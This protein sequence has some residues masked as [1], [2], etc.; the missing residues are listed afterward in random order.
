MDI[1]FIREN[2]ELVDAAAKKK[3]IDF[4]TAKL[5]ELDDKR[6][7][8]LATVEEKRAA[9]NA[10]NIKISSAK[11]PAQRENL[12]KEMKTVKAEL[13]K[14]ETTLKEIIKDWQAEMLRVPNIPDMSVPDGASDAE[15]VELK[16]WGEKPSFNFTAKNHIDLLL[17]H[18]MADFER[19][20]EVSGFRGYF[21]KKD[22]F[23][24][25]F[26]LWQH[27]LDFF[28]KK[29]LDPLL[30]P[31]IVKPFAFLGTGYLPQGA[32]DLYKTQDGDYLSGTAEVP[33]MSYFADS[34]LELASLPKKVLAFSPCYRR[35]AG[36]H[37]KDTKGLMRL[38]E[39]Y[40]FEQVI[41]C[42][43]NHEESVKLHEWITSNAEEFIQSLN[44]PYRVVVNCG[45]DLGLG[46]VKK[47]DIECW[48]PSEN[49]YR[50]THSASYFHDFQ[51]R[52][53]NIKYKDAAGKSQY[54][55]S[56][57]N[58][59]SATP[60][61]LISVVENYQQADGTIRVPE[62]LVKYMGKDVIS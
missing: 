13:E 2:A 50:E 25:M 9:Q 30:A 34:T 12:I 53:L 29:G 58:T 27:A 54:A 38:H 55:H 57:N 62:V 4:N 10:A 39:F 51:T 41:L 5:V 20:A 59:A 32:E 16:N 56:L 23:R 14:E 60:R 17:A 21:L 61:F 36:A 11:D 24:L 26:A 42:E 28:A 48:V 45:G 37:G 44:I 15:N 7:K 40:K 22:G 47:Y 43:A 46:Q 6:R 49:K 8:I 52:R 35:E 18:D 3:R 19:G 33:T 31:S 1:R